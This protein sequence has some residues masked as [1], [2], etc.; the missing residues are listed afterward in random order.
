MIKQGEGRQIFIGS[1]DVFFKVRLEKVR[2]FE[3]MLV[4]AFARTSLSP[5]RREVRA[6]QLLEYATDTEDIIQLVA[7]PEDKE[8]LYTFIQERL[9]DGTIEDAFEVVVAGNRLVAQ[10]IGKKPPPKWHWLDLFYTPPPE[11]G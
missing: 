3:R 4:Q 7:W 5:R 2:P 8:A 1:V 10:P 11:K 6:Y 9:D